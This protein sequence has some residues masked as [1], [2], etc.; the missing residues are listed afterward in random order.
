MSCA[1]FHFLWKYGKSVG[2]EVYEEETSTLRDMS[3]GDQATKAAGDAAN[4]AVD[5]AY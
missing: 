5:G 3:A 2:G 1:S 4:A